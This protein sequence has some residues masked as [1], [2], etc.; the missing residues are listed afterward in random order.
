MKNT[1]NMETLETGGIGNT[2]LNPPRQSQLISWFFTFNNYLQL[3][4]PIMETKFKLICKK[5]R[6]QEE[7]G[8]NGTKHLQGC[9]EL[10]KASRWSEFN[11]SSNIHWEKTNNLDKAMEYCGKAATR[12]GDIYEFGFPKAIKII[13]VLKPWQQSIEDIFHSE[14]NGRSIHWYW[15]TVGGVGKSAFC[16]YMYVKHNA[17]VI[18]GGKLNDIMNLIFNTDMDLCTMIIIDIPRNNRNKVSY[19]SIECI[20]NGMITNTKYETGTKIFNPPHVIVFSN[21]EPDIECLSEDRWIIKE[22]E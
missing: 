5:Y 2:K 21:Y 12:S 13:E 17:L 18:Q 11:L 3:D 14:P 6:F 1:K 16:K 8:E 20:L 7:T 19:N 9:I 4:I 15:E 22:I 10:K